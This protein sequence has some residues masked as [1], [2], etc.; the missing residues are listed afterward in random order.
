M[1]ARTSARKIVTPTPEPPNRSRAAST[2]P[3]KVEKE[4]EKS[5]K[6]KE[7]VEKEKEK[8]EKEKEKVEKAEK[9]EKEKEKTEKEKEKEAVKEAVKEELD[10]A[11]D[12]KN[13]KSDPEKKSKGNGL[14]G[15]SR[16]APGKRKRESDGVESSEPTDESSLANLANKRPAKKLRTSKRQSQREEAKGK[17]RMS[18]SRSN[19]T[20]SLLGDADKGA[21][22]PFLAEEVDF[23]E[24]EK[25]KLEELHDRRKKLDDYRKRTE[26]L[27][28][29]I[30][31]EHGEIV[32]RIDELKAAK[33]SQ[34][35][36][37]TE[38]KESSEADRNS[39]FGSDG[40]EEEGS[41]GSDK[42]E[43]ESE[44]DEEM[45]GNEE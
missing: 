24:Y 27:L 23:R 41:G 39:T 28:E 40:N 2:P 5:E 25:Q 30:Q 45:E 21:S 8:A 14:S 44:N 15:S 12:S 34:Y 9:A 16:P 36:R 7:K 19:S 29:M 32:K 38:M 26:W 22:F 42:K 3:Q 11:E 18:S 43:A 35:N 4:K 10:E 13:E 6:E 20:E 31:E 1:E 33:L 17:G 37:N